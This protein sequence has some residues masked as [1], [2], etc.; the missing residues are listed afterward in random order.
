MYF[1]LIDLSCKISTLMNRNEAQTSRRPTYCKYIHKHIRQPGIKSENMTLKNIIILKHAAV[2][3]ALNLTIY[4][5]NIILAKISYS[6]RKLQ[7]CHSTAYRKVMSD[8][9][10]CW[11]IFIIVKTE[12]RNSAYNDI[13]DSHQ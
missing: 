8:D 13:Y 12:S 1:S 5:F 3:Q 6:C 11:C 10:T 7:V 9:E 4:S 2:C